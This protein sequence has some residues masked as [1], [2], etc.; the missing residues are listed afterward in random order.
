VATKHIIIAIKPFFASEI[1][2]SGY[3]LRDP[4]YG[5]GSWGPL[6]NRARDYRSQSYKT[7][8]AFKKYN[9]VLNYLTVC[10]PILGHVGNL[11]SI[12]VTHPQ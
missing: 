11:T 5:P 8:L 4:K 1:L 10:Y 9:L 12:E 7:I 2:Q 6:S 3:G